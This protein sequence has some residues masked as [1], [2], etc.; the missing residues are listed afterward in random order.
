MDRP[1]I[2]IAG[3]QLGVVI[4]G[5]LRSTP[6]RLWGK[7]PNYERLKALKR[8]GAGDEPDPRREVADYIAARLEELNWE[9]SYP[10]PDA[11]FR[12]SSLSDE[13][14]DRDRG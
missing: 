6:D 1:R 9:V 4:R 2:V 7:D 11:P 3:K 10:S 8:Q 5:W 12:S 13:L 14:G